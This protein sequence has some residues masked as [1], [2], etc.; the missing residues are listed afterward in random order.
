MIAALFI[1][2][3][4][5]N[6]T[7]NSTSSNFTANST[8]SNT[9]AN[10]TSNSTT[11]STTNS[12]IIVTPTAPNEVELALHQLASLFN[13]SFYVVA[14]V[15]ASL[16]CG[17]LFAWSPSSYVDANGTWYGSKKNYWHWSLNNLE[18]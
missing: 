5:P 18:F 7:V 3:T 2:P 6:A 10:S 14:S 1:E 12:T 11:N 8:D 4:T 13:L 15:S 16:F 17:D 9:T